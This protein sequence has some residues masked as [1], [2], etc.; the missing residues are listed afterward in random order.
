M[1][2]KFLVLLAVTS[3]FATT[4]CTSKNASKDGEV[5]AEGD[6]GN[7]EALESVDGE[8]AADGSEKP[9]DETAASTNTSDQLTED[10]LG[11]PAATN[12]TAKT[13]PAPAEIPPQAA[14]ET[15]P[16]A[17]AETLDQ[18]PTNVTDAPPPAESTAGMT[19]ATEEKPKKNVPLQKIATA[20]WQVGTVWFNTVYFARPDDT[21]KSVAKKIYGN[22]DRVKEMK[23]GNPTYQSRDLRPGDK[24]YYNSPHRAEDSSKLI[25]YFEDNGIAPK[26][27]VAKKGDNIR[28]VS[29]DLL[30]YKDAW[31]EVWASNLVESKGELDEG[32]EL[33]YWSEA[34]STQIAANT[35]PMQEPP[36]PSAAMDAPPPPPPPT[37]MA[38]PPP[39]DMAQT[40]P[41]ADL[42]PPPPPMDTA[43]APPPPP[44]MD[45]PPPPP[46]TEM[47]PP[48][49]PPPMAENE[50]IDSAAAG[51]TGEMDQD[52]VLGLAL[53]GVALILI[54]YMFIRN[55]KRKQQEFEQAMSE[56]QVGT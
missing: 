51:T 32:T 20:P 17:P 41:P 22:T 36:P 54:V 25:T 21:L 18:A 8:L 26:T 34:E 4:S 1:I 53:G 44:P 19:E 5:V 31:K 11:E 6:A 23:K 56:T 35:A 42:P 15:P 43:M 12:E 29:K 2:K 50:N 24:V 49:P 33:K 52:M 39:P 10:S 27:Y 48:P 45:A 3:V 47:A 55:K 28:T 9:A 40:P 7:G 46:P 38:P 13:E 14:T 16:P 37:E 30:G